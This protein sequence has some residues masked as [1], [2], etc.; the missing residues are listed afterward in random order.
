MVIED[1][2]KEVIGIMEQFPS[3]VHKIIHGY[4]EKCS[5]Q[6]DRSLK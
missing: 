6:N 1:D 2:L 4:F 3:G 5:F